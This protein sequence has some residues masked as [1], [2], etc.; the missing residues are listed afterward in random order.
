MII[1]RKSS[2]HKHNNLDYQ[3]CKWLY[4]YVYVYVYVNMSYV[5]KAN[6]STKSNLRGKK[7]NL[8]SKSLGHKP[9]QKGT[10]HTLY[11]KTDIIDSEL[12][13]WR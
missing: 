11:Q 3:N 13:K 9:S 4:Q 10:I 7:N 5:T 12:Q 8:V 2:K 6:R 1:G